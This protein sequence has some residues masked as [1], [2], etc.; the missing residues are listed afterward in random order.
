MTLEELAMRR[1]LDLVQAAN[2]QLITLSVKEHTDNE[3]AL[4]DLA[5]IGSQA[6]A[7]SSTLREAES[8]LRGLIEQ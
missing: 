6:S 7:L 2:S 8:W 5:Q 3:C 4:K 1:V